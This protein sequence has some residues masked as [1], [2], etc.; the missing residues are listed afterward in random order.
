MGLGLS[1]GIRTAPVALGLAERLGVNAP[2]IVAVN[3]LLAG[4][5]GLDEIVVPLMARPLKREG[6]TKTSARKTGRSH[7][8]IS[9]V[10]PGASVP[11]WP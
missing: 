6:Q 4:S 1:E 10:N 7:V 8:C 2:L 3:A 9:T 11:R 5:L